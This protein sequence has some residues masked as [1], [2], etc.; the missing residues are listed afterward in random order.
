MNK[1]ENQQVVLE[2]KEK[3]ISEIGKEVF[4]MLGAA[5]Q[6]Q[7]IQDKLPTK[8]LYC[9]AKVREILNNETKQGSN[10]SGK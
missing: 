10:N 3:V 7:L 4:G 6:A 5:Q 1:N 2:A 9:L 8:P